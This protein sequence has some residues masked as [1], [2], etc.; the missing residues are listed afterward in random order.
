MKHTPGPWRAAPQPGQTVGVHRFT[1]CVMVGDDSLADTLTEPDAHLIASA[2]DLLA[3][4]KAVLQ[5]LELTGAY[6]SEWARTLRA[7]I[8]KAEGGEG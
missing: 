7:A 6:G 1:H 5:G 3:A 8:A 2:P 4:C